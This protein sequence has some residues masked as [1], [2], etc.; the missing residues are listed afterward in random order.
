VATPDRLVGLVLMATENGQSQFAVVTSSKTL[1]L[2]MQGVGWFPNPN[3]KMS[4][5]KPN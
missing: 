2:L 5:Q 4:W 1:S 3:R